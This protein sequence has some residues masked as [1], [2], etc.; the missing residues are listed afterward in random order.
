MLS[1]LSSVPAAAAAAATAAA[2]QSRQASRSVLIGL[3][4]SMCI[5]CLCVQL[6]VVP[7]L[8]CLLEELTA[9]L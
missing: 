5:K 7:A 4:L 8:L 2:V 6:C 3:G 9:L 1:W